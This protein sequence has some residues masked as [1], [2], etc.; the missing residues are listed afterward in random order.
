MGTKA[1]VI[2]TQ[3]WT[4]LKGGEF[5]VAPVHKTLL[6]VSKM[7]DNGHRVVF[8]TEWSYVEDIAS[9]ERTTL[10]RKRGLFVL[11]AWVRPRVKKSEKPKE[12]EKP[13]TGEEEGGKPFQRQ[14]R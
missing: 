4:S 14:G 9:G 3:E 8:D 10:K 6:S 5:Q 12:N 2:A 1:G 13:K 7:L 11:Q